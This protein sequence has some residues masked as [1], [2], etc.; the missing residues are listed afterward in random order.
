MAKLKIYTFPDK[1]L[2]QVAQPV[3][4]VLPRH[5]QLSKDMLETMY[6]APGIGLAGNQIG[7]LERI[8]VIDIDFSLENLSEGEQ[9]PEGAEIVEDGYITD[10]NPRIFINPKIIQSE[11]EIVFCEGCLSVPEFTADVKR[12]EKITLEYIDIQGDQQELKAEDLLA[13]CIQH[14]IDHLE[15][16]LFIDRL[17]PL[18][19]EMAKKKLL[20]LRKEQEKDN[21]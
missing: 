19:K 16:K 1:I 17:S 11:G 2:S 13:I 9:A 8:I 4:K 21:L 5:V 7:I 14:E 18:K 20:K 12:A 3:E 10:K 15:G 6:D